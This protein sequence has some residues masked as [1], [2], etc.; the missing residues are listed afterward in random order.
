VT[1]AAGQR[2]LV[3][4]ASLAGLTTALALVRTGRRVLVVERSGRAPRNGAAMAVDLRDLARVTGAPELG[5]A[6]GGWLPHAWTDLQRMLLRAAESAPFIDCRFDTA[7]VVV[8]TGE[9]G[10]WVRT[11]H[12]DRLDADFVV[13]ADGHASVVRA[14]VDPARPHADYAG[15]APVARGGRR[16]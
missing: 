16:A 3:V 13:G 4:G 12:G 8:G 15:Y 5:D 11:A 6:A 2:A 9:D 10:A 14:A 1:A 7:V